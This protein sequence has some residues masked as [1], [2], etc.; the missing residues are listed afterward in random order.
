MARIVRGVPGFAL[1]LG[2]DLDGVPAGIRDVLLSL[3]VREA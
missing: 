2:S 3:G 1:E